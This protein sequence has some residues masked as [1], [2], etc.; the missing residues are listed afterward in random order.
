MLPLKYLLQEIN[1]SE[2]L[3]NSNV[4]IVNSTQTSVKSKILHWSSN[5]D[6]LLLSPLLQWGESAD[7]KYP[8][9]LHSNGNL[10]LCIWIH[11][12]KSFVQKMKL[13]IYFSLSLENDGPCNKKGYFKHCFF[14]MEN[15]CVGLFYLRIFVNIS[16][17]SRINGREGMCTCFNELHT[18]CA[19]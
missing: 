13:K 18:L 16:V 2:Q 4:L 10:S 12:K 14:K 5:F 1:F 7:I 8:K 6:W 15:I 17:Y 3:M 11:F 19:V 9:W